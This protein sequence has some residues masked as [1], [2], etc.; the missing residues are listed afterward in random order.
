VVGGRQVSALQKLAHPL[1]GDAALFARGHA[2]S[3]P[4]RLQR[5]THG[6]CQVCGSFAWV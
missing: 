2:P 4:H 5:V 1:L 6:R 3:V